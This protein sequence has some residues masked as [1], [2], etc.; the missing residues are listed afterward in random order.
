MD[1]ERLL[2]TKVESFIQANEMLEKEVPVLVGLSGGADSTALLDCLLT[3]GYNC[4]AAHCNFQLRGDESVRDHEFARM[5][6]HNYGIPFYE[7]SFDTKLY[8]SRR[9]I[10]IEMACRELRYEWFEEILQQTQAQAIAVAHHRD[11]SIET[12]FLNLLRGTGIAGLTGINAV[13]GNVVRPFL[14]VS[15][16]EIEEYLQKKHIDYITDSS[17]KEDIYQRN[18][19]RLQL[20]PLLKSMNPAA[21]ESIMRTIGNLQ[22]V[23]VI[24]EDSIKK[25]EMKVVTVR[26]DEVIISIP[27]LQ[28]Q[29]VPKALLF[30][31]LK[32]YDVPS[33]MIDDIESSLDGLSGKQFFSGSYR[34][35]K[36][37][38][39]LIISKRETRDTDFRYFISKEETSISVP[40]EMQFEVMDYFPG[41]II[42]RT[43][44]SACFDADLIN[45]PLELRHWKQ[46]D[47][48]VPF[49]MRGY[50]KLSD[51]FSDHKYS[52]VEK[53][54][55]W[56]LLSGDDIVWLVGERSDNRYRVTS[57]TKRVLM[58]TMMETT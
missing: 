29:P 13:H 25:G 46:G 54:K 21:S 5:Q 37:R 39:V 1:S 53:E 35:V 2:L 28:K 17:N 20:I 22:Q 31:I 3:L 38:D 56:L 48:F 52:V 40:M 43:K 50:K 8:A 27:E 55:A 16:D 12:F 11:D 24:Y 34:I 4:I 45:W 57:K 47:K 44:E 26:G 58:V 7:T 33:A 15:R 6:A 19:I 51:Y 49:G 18:K 41:F 23:E 42:P 30:E 36:D 14:I 9:G 32:E 10:S